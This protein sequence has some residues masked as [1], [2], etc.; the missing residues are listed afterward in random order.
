MHALVSGM[1]ASSAYVVVFP[2]DPRVPF[3]VEVERQHELLPYIVSHSDV[4]SQSYLLKV[5]VNSVPSTVTL[6]V[7]TTG[8]M[9]DWLVM[10]LV[11]TPTNPVTEAHYCPVQSLF[12]EQVLRFG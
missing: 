2:S 9:Q 4:L 8:V 6:F 5:A 1:V 10:V 3:S 7:L 12:L 11:L